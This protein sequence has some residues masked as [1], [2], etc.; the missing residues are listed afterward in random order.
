MLSIFLR[1]DSSSEIF[2]RA[3]SGS[4][5]PPTCGRAVGEW[6][7]RARYLPICVMTLFPIASSG[8]CSIRAARF[9]TENRGL[10]RRAAERLGMGDY[11]PHPRQSLAQGLFQPVD[12]GMDEFDAAGTIDP[13][14]EGH[15]HPVVIDPDPH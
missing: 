1:R 14:M 7:E 4:C 15:E 3:G 2:G 12:R 5:G 10:V 6:I 9:G 11:P 8:R 13:T